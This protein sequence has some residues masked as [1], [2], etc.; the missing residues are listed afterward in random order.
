[1]RVTRNSFEDMNRTGTRKDSMIK[2]KRRQMSFFSLFAD[3]AT[4]FLLLL[5]Y[6]IQ[7][8]S[9]LSSGD[10]VNNRQGSEQI[11]SPSIKLL[12]AF[13]SSLL[14]RRK[15]KKKSQKMKRATLVLLTIKLLTMKK[16]IESAFG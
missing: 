8:F 16:E 11:F 14:N 4:L 7:Y 2:K 9:P 12:I 13:V 10:D 15:R 5:Y 6:W 1:M 3:F